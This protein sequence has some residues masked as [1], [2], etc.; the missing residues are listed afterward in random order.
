[1]LYLTVQT[2]WSSKWWFCFQCKF[3]ASSDLKLMIKVSDCE[4]VLMVF[5]RA[6]TQQKICC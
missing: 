4:F 1:V 6:D 3:V 5:Y 2:L